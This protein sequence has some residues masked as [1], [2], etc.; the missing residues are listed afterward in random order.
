ML[1]T[2][3]TS[4]PSWHRT[5]SPN[6]EPNSHICESHVRFLHTDTVRTPRIPHSTHPYSNFT[7]YII[8]YKSFINVITF[9]PTILTSK[10]I[11]RNWVNIFY[12][13][14][15]NQTK[16]LQWFG[17]NTTISYTALWI[18]LSTKLQP[19]SW[20]NQFSFISLHLHISHAIHYFNKSNTCIFTF[21]CSSLKWNH[22]AY[23]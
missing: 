3:I 6:H 18:L 15:Q 1:A 5:I 14:S 12:K 7:T 8:I 23:K 21:P 10:Y 2:Q 13:N 9:Q 19:N 4:F 16:H 20:G 22:S 11:N 17:N